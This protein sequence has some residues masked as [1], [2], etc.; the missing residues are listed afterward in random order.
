MAN[1]IS[2]Q[3]AAYLLLTFEVVLTISQ[4]LDFGAVLTGLNEENRPI[5]PPQQCFSV[6]ECINLICKIRGSANNVSSVSVQPF[7]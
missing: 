1:Q 3:L 2:I 6:Q 5:S 4:C 7:I